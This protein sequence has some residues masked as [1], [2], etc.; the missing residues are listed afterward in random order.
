MNW[1]HVEAS[2]VID[3]PPEAVYAV[4]SD[5][6]VGHPAIL[7]PAFSPLIV[8]KGG[9][10]AGTVFRC[11]VTIWGSTNA[12]HAEVTEPEPGHLLVETDLESG[13]Y[14]HFIVEP[15][16]GRTQSRMTFSSEFPRPAGIQGFLMKLMM[17][18]VVQKMY[19]EELQNLA[20]YV[21]RKQTAT[22]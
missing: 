5:Y 13:Q 1:I 9:K 22:A 14:T 21:A 12:M 19:Q 20:N 10:G 6:Q 16:N 3:A 4:I 17:P 8:E 15:L 7:P 11:S 18:S 2:R